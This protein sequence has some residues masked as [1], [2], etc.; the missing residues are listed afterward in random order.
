MKSTLATIP[1]PSPDDKPAEDNVP[2]ADRDNLQSYFKDV[3]RY[4]VLGEEETIRLVKLFQK[5]GDRQAAHLLINSNL[6]LVVKITMDFRRHW[7]PGFLDLVQEGN[8]GLARSISKFDPERGIKFS[9]YAAFWI[10][11][12]IRKHTM[13]TKRLVKIGTT[14]VQRK[15]FYSLPKETR[16][17]ETL[18]IKAD[19]G[20]LAKSLDAS[21]KDIIEMAQRLNGSEVSI[22]APLM[23]DT[24]KTRNEMLT[25][26]GPSLEDIVSSRETRKLVRDIINKLRGSFNDREKAVLADRLLSN[27]AKTLQT[28][29]E[30]FSISRERVRQIEINLL[31]KLKSAFRREMPDY[32]PVF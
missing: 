20:T 18:G 17:L 11:A 7:M 12:Y 3:E 2:T 21:E 16:R 22:D 23:H 14:Q 31:G 26:D 6:R 13:D 8:L 32:E 24:E 4:K 28:I 5:T 10:R 1:P 9:Y 30:K 19:P 25:D 27:D 15:L 29:A